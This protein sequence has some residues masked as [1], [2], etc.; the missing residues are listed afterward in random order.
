[1]PT[2][3]KVIFPP[4]FTKILEHKILCLI[5]IVIPVLILLLKITG[6]YQ[7]KCLFY[8]I[9]NLPCPMCGMTRAF[10]DIFTGHFISALKLHILSFVIFFFWVLTVVTTLSPLKLREKIILNVEKLENRTAFF[11]VFIVIYL[12]YGIAR[13]FMLQYNFY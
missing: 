5:L 6:I 13:M 7:H 9:T 8:K 12:C 2:S 1:M 3:K 10:S 4:V 11:L